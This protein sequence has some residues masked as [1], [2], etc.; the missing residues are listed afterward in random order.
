MDNHSG[1]LL[2]AFH[3]HEPGEMTPAV[4]VPPPA[5]MFPVVDLSSALQR[6]PDWLMVIFCPAIMMEAA[7]AWDVVLGSKLNLTCPLPVPVAPEI[8]FSHAPSLEEVHPQFDPFEATA[9]VPVSVEEPN[10]VLLGV[11]VKLQ[12]TPA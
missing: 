1:L 5:G 7:R 8:T 10:S 3:V 9:I 11:M 2:L 4:P 12:L 6:I